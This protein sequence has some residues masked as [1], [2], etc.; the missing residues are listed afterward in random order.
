[1]K[2]QLPTAVGGGVGLDPGTDLD[3][4]EA[5]FVLRTGRLAAVFLAQQHEPDR[6][7]THGADRR[8]R[9]HDH[10]DPFAGHIRPQP[11]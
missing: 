5:A 1:M 7:R 4:L 10:D 8:E 3:R 6:E 2:V 9:V 11:R